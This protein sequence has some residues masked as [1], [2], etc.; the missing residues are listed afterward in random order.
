MKK[1]FFPAH[2]IGTVSAPA[3]KS[4]AHRRMICAGLT[5]GETMLTGFMDSADMAATMRCLGALGSTFNRDG[6]TLTISGMQ[7]KIAKMPVMDCGESGSTLRFFAPIALTV[8]GGTVF[9]MHGRLGSRPMD[10]YRD[11]F[12]PRGVRWY[13]GVGADGAAELTVRGKMEPGDYVL[14]GDVSSQFVSGLLFALTIEA[15]AASGIEVQESNAFSWRIPG[16]QQYKSHS[17]HLNGDYSQAAVLCCAGALGHD[18]TVT[19]LSPVTTQGDRAILSHLMALGATVEESDSHIRVKADKLHGATLDMHDCP[20]IAPILA[21]TAQ[22]AEGESRLTHCGRLRLKECDRLAATVEILNLLGGDAKADGDDIVLHGVKQLRGGVTLPN[23]GDHRMVML[24]SIAA[25]K[26]EQ[27]I[28][29]DGIEAIDKSWPEY[30][31]VYQM[32]G[33]KCE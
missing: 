28:E 16:H 22:L 14:P 25:T 19:H 7:G 15:I 17:C 2:L 31:K 30:L 13:M 32:L 9:R 23:Y 8:A 26:C 20:D 24:A 12:V 10:V 5:Q 27:P 3:S 21:L 4:E 1:T 11:L 6:D 18:I 33:G 29:M